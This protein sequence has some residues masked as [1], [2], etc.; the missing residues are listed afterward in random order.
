MM[1]KTARTQ[2]NK[3]WQS[4]IDIRLVGEQQRE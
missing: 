4:S 2:V 1:A 3:R